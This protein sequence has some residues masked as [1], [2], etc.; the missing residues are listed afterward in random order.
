MAAGIPGALVIKLRARVYTSLPACL[1]FFVS[2]S[3]R[4]QRAY[5]LRHILHAEKTNG[6]PKGGEHRSMSTP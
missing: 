4:M 3:T 2:Y 6:R 1:W 5:Y